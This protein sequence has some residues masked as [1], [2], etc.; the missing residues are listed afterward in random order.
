MIVGMLNTKD[1]SGYF[2]P[3]KGLAKEIITVPIS[4]SAAGI[5]PVALA[6]IAQ[7]NGIPSSAAGSL[8]EALKRI[9]LQNLRPA[10]RILVGGSLYLAGAALAANGTPPV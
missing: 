3:F 6:R 5:E 9:D 2:A 4:G 8:D 1:P 10:P 7:E